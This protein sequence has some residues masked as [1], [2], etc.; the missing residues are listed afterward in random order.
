MSGQVPA[1]VEAQ[2]SVASPKCPRSVWL[3]WFALVVL[4]RVSPTYADIPAPG[5]EYVPVHIRVAN[6][7]QYPE[8]M[9]LFIDGR[10][11]HQVPDSGMSVSGSFGGTFNALRRAEFAPE[12]IGPGSDAEFDYFGNHPH[13]IRSGTEVQ[14]YCTVRTGD[15]TAGLDRVFRITK[16]T[17]E[18]LSLEHTVNVVTLRDGRKVEKPVA[19]NER[20]LPRISYGRDMGRC[21]RI[22]N[23]AD[24]PDYTFV[25]RF[26]WGYTIM[27]PGRNV[28]FGRVY[29]VKKA[30]FDPGEIPCSHAEG[31]NYYVDNRRLTYVPFHLSIERSKYRSWEIAGITDVFAIDGISGSNVRLHP[32]CVEYTDTTG[33]V[34]QMPAADVVYDSRPEPFEGTPDSVLSRRYTGWTLYAHIENIDSFPDLVFL[35]GWP[36]SRQVLTSHDTFEFEPD[37]ICVARKSGFVAAQ[38]GTQDRRA[39]FMR[40]AGAVRVD[41]DLSKCPFGLSGEASKICNFRLARDSSGLVRSKLVRIVSVKEDGSN[42][43]FDISDRGRVNGAAMGEARNSTLPRGFRQQRTS[44]VRAKGLPVWFEWMWF[45]GVP[46]LAVVGIAL[47]LFR[48]KSAPP[49]T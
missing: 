34:S 11:W 24:Y 16:L 25:M 7:N 33:R 28:L 3:A 12:E 4:A 26:Q 6:L 20:Q 18:T 19:G 35:R 43:V 1:L 32:V 37:T 17:D 39:A 45:V 14:T 30:G 41:L 2:P 49:S 15:P 23:M 47:V 27:K 9:L 40:A 13:I 29:V 5:W 48:H 44:A 31:W 8:F 22:Q 38:L 42:E 36:R 46:L 10:G 21:I